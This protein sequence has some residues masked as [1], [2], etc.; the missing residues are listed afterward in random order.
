MPKRWRIKREPSVKRDCQALT[1]GAKLL[2]QEISTKAAL[3][4]A[5]ASGNLNSFVRIAVDAA[6]EQGDK[7]S[8]KQ[9]AAEAAKQYV[10]M[11]A[12]LQARGLQAAASG[13]NA[14]AAGKQAIVAET[15]VGKDE[16]AKREERQRKRS[17][18]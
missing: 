4:K 5:A 16:E 2:E 10:E 18:I 7:R 1:I 6:V 14:A 11:T 17:R 3:E 8:P 9:I 12:A 15:K 13:A